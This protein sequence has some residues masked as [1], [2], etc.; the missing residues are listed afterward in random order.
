MTQQAD[1]YAVLFEPVKI[2]PLTARN[3]FYQVPHCTG[4]GRNYPSVSAHIRATNAEGGWA[5]VVHT[6]G[7]AEL[8]DALAA[9]MGEMAWEMRED[10]WKSERVEVSEA[11]GRAYAHEDGLLILSDTGDSVYG[12]APGD[13]T[14]ILKELLAQATAQP[15]SD[16]PMLVPIVDPDAVAVARSAGIGAEVTVS[17]GGKIDN[18]FSQPIETTARVVAISETVSYTHLTLPTKA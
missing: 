16:R 7:D 11:V 5:V 1:P 9:E 4:A 3:R 8:A 13:S 6:D 12:G 17:L 10:F 18:E 2:G 15:E 14:W